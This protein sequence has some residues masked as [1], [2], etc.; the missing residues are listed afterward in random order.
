[1]SSRAHEGPCPPQLFFKSKQSHLFECVVQTKIAATA[2][3]QVPRP[4]LP[5]GL[6][7]TFPPWSP[8]GALRLTLNSHHHWTQ[9]SHIQKDFAQR[10]V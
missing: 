2:A 5:P 8:W 3:F 10:V 6:Q 1:M 4:E 7:G 9:T